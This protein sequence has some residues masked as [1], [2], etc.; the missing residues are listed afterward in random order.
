MRDGDRHTEQQAREREAVVKGDFIAK[1]G[2][3]F[4]ATA[5]ISD[6]EMSSF[7]SAEHTLVLLLLERRVSALAYA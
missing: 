7:L 3:Q 4:I 1:K 6:Q 2:G 5:P